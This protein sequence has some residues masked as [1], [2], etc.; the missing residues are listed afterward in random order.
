LPS[1]TWGGGK[2]QAKDSLDNKEKTKGRRKKII[3]A[4]KQWK[5]PQRKG[6]CGKTQY[7]KE[8][9]PA[10]QKDLNFT[11][12]RSRGDNLSKKEATAHWGHIH[13]K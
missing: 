5:K 10:W 2:K 8:P 6:K 7:I 12:V 9:E 13:H 4:S 3:G 1:K 11:T